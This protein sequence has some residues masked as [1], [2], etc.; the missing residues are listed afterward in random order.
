MPDILIHLI[1]CDEEELKTLDPEEV[2]KLKG[3]IGKTG[4]NLLHNITVQGGELDDYFHLVAGRVRL[5]VFRELGLQTIPCKVLDWRLTPEQC[6]DIALSENLRRHNLAWYDQIE[7]EEK[8]HLLR[9]HQHGQ[10]P[11]GRPK[12]DKIG[13]TQAD[14][15]KELGYSLGRM[16]QDLSLANAI[17]A[18]P[19]L[20]KVQDKKTALRLIRH[21][22]TRERMLEESLAPD[23]DNFEMNQIFLGNSLDILANLPNELFDAC[24]TDPPWSQYKDDNLTMDESTVGVFKEVYRVLKRDSFL[25]LI[26]SSTDIPLYQKRLAEFGFRVQQYPLIWA[27]SGTITHGKRPW[28]YARDYEPIILAV[29]G[30]PV[31]SSPTEISSIFT[32]PSMHHTK[33]VHP[34]EKPIELLKRIIGQC[35]FEGAKILE[36]FAGSGV[37]LQAAAEMDRQYIGIER[38]QKFYNNILKRLGK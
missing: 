22:A 8:L 11:T 10:A 9:L 33:M 35:T 37:C 26:T 12:K 4:E 3:E 28:E 6:Q 17:R 20:K 38:D 27:K 1:E 36:P 29:K 14:T 13:W 19:S 7:L 15:A 23:S 25:Y 32:Y 31:L 18:N 2:S 24:I 5:R 34:H 21:A 30:D 16:S